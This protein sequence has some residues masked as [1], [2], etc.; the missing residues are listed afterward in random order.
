MVWAIATS[1]LCA[2]R[3]GAQ[4][5]MD[6]ALPAE[7]QAGKVSCLETTQRRYPVYAHLRGT[8]PRSHSPAAFA[9]TRGEDHG[10]G[11]AARGDDRQAGDGRAQPQGEAAARVHHVYDGDAAARQQG[12]A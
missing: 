10:G 3:I 9:R 2:Y 7:R 5:V 8:I 6:E 12:L 1:P 11:L 4:I